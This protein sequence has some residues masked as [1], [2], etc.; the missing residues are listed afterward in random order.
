[1]LVQSAVL[2]ATEVLAG[3]IEQK[4]TVVGPGRGVHERVFKDEVS[5]LVFEKKFGRRS[6]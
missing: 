3:E 6:L 2:T 5:L 1:M 4:R